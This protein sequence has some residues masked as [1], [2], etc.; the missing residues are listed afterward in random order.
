MSQG[1]L[2]GGEFAGVARGE[3]IKIAT[4]DNIADDEIGGDDADIYGDIAGDL[5]DVIAEFGFATGVFDDAAIPWLK[6]EGKVATT[7]ASAGG[8][9]RG[10]S[11]EVSEAKHRN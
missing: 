8:V 11:G 7:E 3:H 6:T 1:F 10:R 2:T 4:I 9:S 5:L